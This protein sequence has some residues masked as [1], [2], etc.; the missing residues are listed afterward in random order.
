MA[1]FD[2][3]ADAGGLRC[4]N[5]T[6]KEDEVESTGPAGVRKRVYFVDTIRMGTT[7]PSRGLRIMNRVVRQV[8]R[9]LHWRLKPKLRATKYC[10]FI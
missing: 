9:R 1:H 6:L 3:W 10:K 7:Q 8:I 5:Y 4:R 2:V